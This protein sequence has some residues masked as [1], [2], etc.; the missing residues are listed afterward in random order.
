[1][2]TV[3]HIDS[4]S[5]QFNSVKDTED[6][7]NKTISHATHHIK[8]MPID[9]QSYYYTVQKREN[10]ILTAKNQVLQVISG[11]A[12]VSCGGQDYTL[13][14]GDAITL[15]S[16]GDEVVVVSGLKGKAVCYTLKE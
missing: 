8:A 6:H 3:F 16:H 13:K 15:C 12:W 7:K 5:N 4:A 14:S 11:V 9:K 1:M 2:T 10:H